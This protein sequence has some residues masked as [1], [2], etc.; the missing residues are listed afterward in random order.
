MMAMVGGG[1]GKTQIFSYGIADNNSVNR[2]GTVDAIANVTFTVTKGIM[3][4]MGL[5]VKETLSIVNKEKW[6]NFS[7]EIQE[8]LQKEARETFNKKVKPNI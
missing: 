6:D 4:I 3:G 2:D 8:Q 1:D 7:K 5:N